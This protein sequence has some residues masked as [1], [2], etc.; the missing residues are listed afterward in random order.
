MVF[1]ERNDQIHSQIKLLL[2]K[3]DKSPYEHHGLDIDQFL[4]ETNSE[5]WEAVCSFTE[6]L[7]HVLLYNYNTSG[8]FQKKV[9]VSV[10]CQ[11]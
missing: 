9:L 1:D 4:K 8:G 3:D 5:V 2:E 6:L 11:V 7:Q 10:V